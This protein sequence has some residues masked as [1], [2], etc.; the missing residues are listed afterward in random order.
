MIEQI[1]ALLKQNPMISCD[2]D[3]LSDDDN[4]YEAGLTSFASVQMMLAIEEEFDIEFP[5]DMLTR[6][7]FSSLANVAAAVSDLTREAA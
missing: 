3:A 5:E 1:R 7:T 4:L 2:I 6:R